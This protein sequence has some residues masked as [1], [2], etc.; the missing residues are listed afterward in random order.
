MQRLVRFIMLG[1]RV[2]CLLLTVTLIDQCDTPSLL[3]DYNNTGLPNPFLFNDGT[4]VRTKEDWQC[5]RAQIAS[6][7][8]GYEAGAL[9]PKPPI[10]TGSFNKSGATGTLTITAGIPGA[11]VNWTNTITYPSGNPPPK[12]WPMVIGY[13]GGSI[14]VPS[15][16][17][18]SSIRC[19]RI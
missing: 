4:P 16:V 7:I 2:M 18:L 9:P 10:V 3:P 13:D 1:I 8:K 15:G 14:P 12:G 6:L 11:T 17:C 5:R 19:L